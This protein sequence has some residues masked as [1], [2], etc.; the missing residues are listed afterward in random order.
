MPEMETIPPEAFLEP[1]PPTIRTIAEALRAIVRQVV[2]DAIEAVR[3]GWRLIGYKVP[4][5]RRSIYFAYVAPEPIHVHL[6][7]E[8]GIFMND[9][10]GRLEG[11][12]LNLRKVRYLTVRSIDEVDKQAFRALVREAVRVAVMPM[13]GRLATLLDRDDGGP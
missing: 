7:F 8:H 4:V 9:P 10:D 3:P 6:G 12:H 2:P 5:G 1:Y 13:E 11:A